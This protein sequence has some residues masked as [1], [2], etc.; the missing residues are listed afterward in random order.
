[1]AG[2]YNNGNWYGL[3][4]DI[5]IGQILADLVSA[6]MERHNYG[7]GAHLDFT[8]H[9][10]DGDKHYPVYED[11]QGMSNNE[12]ELTLADIEANITTMLS[13]RPIWRD[14]DDLSHTFT[15][16]SDVA[17]RMGQPTVP[18]DVR[19][20]VALWEWYK[21]VISELYVIHESVDAHPLGG[22]PYA[23]PEYYHGWAN[24]WPDTHVIAQ[25]AWDALL[26]YD[27]EPYWNAVYR[28]RITNQWWHTFDSLFD[29]H[30]T[31]YYYRCFSLKWDV[32]T[33]VANHPI[34]RG[35][36]TVGKSCSEVWDPGEEANTY[37]PPTPSITFK[38][39]L[40]DVEQ[41][42]V[43][44]D[45]NDSS[46]FDD[47]TEEEIILPN[48]AGGGGNI[49]LLT[50]DHPDLPSSF[51]FAIKPIINDPEGTT[52]REIYLDLRPIRLGAC[53]DLRST[54]N[55]D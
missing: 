21:D 24:G 47:P 50:I 30:Y 1:M 46:D 44:V 40:N 54:L 49:I 9:T 32:P 20:R 39:Y 36:L 15:S 41:G 7:D 31:D 25:E 12:I 48:Y 52:Q 4:A 13:E 43:T 8:F 10:L 14:P 26:L 11:F 33:F 35:T 53:F 2:W 42:D 45:T 27:V 29:L 18:S 3:H 51:K 28:A 34:L 16:F 19:T 17:T 23:S 22:F 5:A 37:L 55:Y 6:I 38:V